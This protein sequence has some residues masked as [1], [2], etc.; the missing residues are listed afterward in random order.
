MKIEPNTQA[1]VVVDPKTGAVVIGEGVQISP[2]AVSLGTGQG[3]EIPTTI[4]IT[5]V[6]SAGTT[7]GDVISALKSVGTKTED[8][9]EVL[10]LMEKAGALHA[11]LII[12]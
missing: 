7:L 10:K 4:N 3:D 9:I 11:T 6:S 12:M 8:L 2:F 1:T 5:P